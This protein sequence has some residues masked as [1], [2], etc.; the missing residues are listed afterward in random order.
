MIFQL[1]MFN[2]SDHKG[3]KCINFK[4]LAVQSSSRLNISL[5]GEL[6][7]KDYLMFWEK[8]RKYSPNLINYGQ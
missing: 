8:Y 5:G 7:W 6:F 3:R 1:L 4:M 2:D